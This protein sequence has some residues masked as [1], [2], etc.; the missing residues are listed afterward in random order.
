MRSA[1]SLMPHQ[2]SWACRWSADLFLL[3]FWKAEQQNGHSM[4][5]TV[6]CRGWKETESE[7]LH[8]T[9]RGWKEKLSSLAERKYRHITWSMDNVKFGAGDNLLDQFGGQ[10]H[11][12]ER[13]KSAI[14]LKWGRV[15]VVCVCVCVCVC[16]RACGGDG[17]DGGGG[18]GAVCRKTNFWGIFF[19]T[20]THAHE[21]KLGQPHLRLEHSVPPSEL[22]KEAENDEHTFVGTA[23]RHCGDSAPSGN[24]G[25][26]SAWKN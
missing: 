19:F 17:G 23:A 15:C 13:A 3:L 11:A 9:C 1:N 24:V 16:V 7:Y 20:Q 14:G 6:N 10:Q 5:T 2:R 26:T 21:R 12:Q 22:R 8:I 4:A 18:G 25:R